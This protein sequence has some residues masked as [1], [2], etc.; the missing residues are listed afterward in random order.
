MI[1]Y[2]WN[3]IMKKLLHN[4]QIGTNKRPNIIA[5]IVIVH[6]QEMKSS[7]SL[8]FPIDILEVKS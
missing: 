5:Y 8:V 7:V 1:I 2:E 6:K 4:V 3:K